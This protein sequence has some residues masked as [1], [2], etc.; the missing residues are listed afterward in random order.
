MF[1]RMRNE[2][3]LMDELLGVHELGW[4]QTNHQTPSAQIRQ[5]HCTY[6]HYLTSRITIIIQISCLRITY[7]CHL[8]AYLP[9]YIANNRL[10]KCFSICL[11]AYNIHMRLL[12]STLLTIDHFLSTQLKIE[13]NHLVTGSYFKSWHSM[14]KYTEVWQR[15]I[16]LS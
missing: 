12:L 4:G 1:S 5:H 3:A 14:N 2:D 16:L 6:S 8:R 11:C 15:N 9:S 10:E 7:F 13:M